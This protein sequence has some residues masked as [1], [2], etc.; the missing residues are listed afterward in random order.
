MH[1]HLVATAAA[2]LLA[3]AAA[4][5]AAAQPPLPDTPV[6]RQ[7]AWMIASVDGRAAPLTPVVARRHVAPSF[8]RALP[9]AQFVA[10]MRQTAAQA[11][12]IRVAG[13]AGHPTPT[14]AIALIETRTH[15]KLAIYASV[16]PGARHRITGLEFT[17]RPGP[18]A[19]AIAEPGTYTGAFDVGGHRLFLNCSGSGEPTVVLEA[20]AGGGSSA[21]TRVQRPLAVT[22]RVCSYD[23]S[24]VPGG[25]S[26]P[27]RKPQD[28]AGIVRD[29]HRLLQKAGVPGPYVLAGHSNG[30]LFARLYATT[31]PDEVAGLV[32]VDSVSDAEPAETRTLYRRLLS[33][34]QWRAYQALLRHP[35]PLVEYVGDEQV[36][37]ATSFAQMTRA[38]RSHPLPAM[39]LV[40]I[41]HGIADPAGR[42]EIPGLARET[43]R[44][45]QRMQ[46]GLARL[47]P[48]GRRVV[49]AR[50][51]HQIPAEQPAVVI[52]A[53]RSVLQAVR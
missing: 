45:W 13:F 46:A 35:P 42:E 10:V 1:R 8:F 20:G 6:G 43:E 24:H 5:T 19:A 29:L 9:V 12:P 11:G 39:P 27:V 15:Q 51:H 28:A 31:Y 4:A 26:D 48:G 18:G 44:S 37:M 49:A 40:V 23:R 14:D 22:T 53:L 33:P 2:A 38:Q 32:L 16:E 52:A 36:D 34:R 25:S 3:A 30:G 17:E 47:V 50:S 7:L 41:S 21:W